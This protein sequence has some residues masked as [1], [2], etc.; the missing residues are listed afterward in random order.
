M[1]KILIL[2]ASSDIGYL[3][4]KLFLQKGWRVFAHYNSNIRDLQKIK[5]HNLKLIKLDFLNDIKIIKEKIDFFKKSK[6]DAFINLVGSIVNKNFNNFELDDCV[7]TIKIN[8]IV[9]LII[10]QKIIKPMI[11]SNFGRIL[12]TSSIGT[13]FGGSNSTFCYS[14]SK[15]A[16]EFIPKDFKIWAKKNVL[17][18]CLIIGV[19]NTKIHKKILKK[20]LKKRKKLIPIGRMAKPI[21][22]AEYIYFLINDN[23]FITGQTISISGGE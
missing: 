3:T 15:K 4:T 20:D 18:N 10:L 19:T 8:T 1:R 12:L 17:I 11:K 23:T 22:I 13:K 16:N 14:L 6:L 21:E 9:P 5:N 7:N 2:G